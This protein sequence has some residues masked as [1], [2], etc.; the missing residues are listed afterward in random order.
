MTEPEPLQIRIIFPFPNRY[1]VRTCGLVFTEN[2]KIGHYLHE[3]CIKEVLMTKRV[4]VDMKR[5]PNNTI[6][7]VNYSY[8]TNEYKTKILYDDE[9]DNYVFEH[10]DFKK[11]TV[12]D[13]T[14]PIDDGSIVKKYVNMFDHVIIIIV[15]NSPIIHYCGSH[16]ILK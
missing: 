13:I 12:E 8:Y 16:P 11:F 7:Y 14:S 6:N 10:V 3:H 15:M 9:I 4:E 2:S 1:K 5:I